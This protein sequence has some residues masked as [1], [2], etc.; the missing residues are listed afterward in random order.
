MAIFDGLRNVCCRLAGFAQV[1]KRCK[2]CFDAE[3]ILC[4]HCQYL[5]DGAEISAFRAI[6]INKTKNGE[7]KNPVKK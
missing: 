7:M 4:R 2:A 5:V 3:I 1:A 6:L